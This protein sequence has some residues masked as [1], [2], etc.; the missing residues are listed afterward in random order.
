[1][2]ARW[3]RFIYRIRRLTLVAAIP[4]LALAAYGF[5][6]GVA[7]NFNGQPPVEAGRAATLIDRELPKL[8]NPFDLIFTSKTAR[9]SDAA[10]RNAMLSA[11]APLAT[12]PRV[13]VIQTPYTS[14]ASFRALVSRNGH[15]AL[16]IVSVNGTFRQ[17]LDAYPSLRRRV[18]SDT[19]RID[20]TGNLAINQDFNTYLNGDLARSSGVVLPLALILLLIVFGTIVSAVLPLGVAALALVAGLAS[21]YVLGRFTDITQY[22]LNLVALIGLGVAIDYSLFITSRFRQELA[23][24]RDVGESVSMAVATAGRAIFFSGLTVAIGLSGMFFYQGIY[25]ATMGLAGA[26]AIALAVLCAL[27][28]LPALLG[29][30]GARV[31]RL[32][33]PLVGGKPGHDG[34]FWHA[35][36]TWVM[37]HPVSALIPAVGFLLL[38]SWPI[39]HINLANSD[40]RALPPQAPTRQASDLITRDFPREG[41]NEVLAVLDY[42]DGNPLSP[43]RVGYLYDLNRRVAG[44]A[45]VRQ[46]KSPLDAAPGLS[47]PATIALLTKPADQQTPAVRQVIHQ[48]SGR[49]IVELDILSHTRVQSSDAR[50]LVR[51]I[52]ALPSPPGG[53]HLVT[54]NTAFD[55]DVI[56]YVKSRTVPAVAFIMVVTY[57]I[58]FLLVG[59]LI[60]PL[61][62]VFMNLLSIS[63]S[64]GAL[65][66]IFQEGHLRSQLNFTPQEID[67]TTLILLFCIVFGLSMDY[68][69]FLL[70]RIQ[71]QFRLCDD[72]RQ[73][74]ATGLEKSG[75]LITGA[76]AIM[77][78][79]FLAFGGLANTVIIKEIGLGLAIAV[80]MDATIV[81]GV[82]VP[83]LM[84]LLG[85]VNWWAPES[86]KRIYER[87]GLEERSAAPPEEALEPTPLKV[88]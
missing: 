65:V 38:V 76:A 40:I 72:T 67:P 87:L 29:V 18:H 37:R 42:P 8:P 46:L 71:E 69:V 20:A 84:R 61:K 62:A 6:A 41:Q 80:A 31:N 43:R 5:V 49:H 45:G 86:L 74:V 4:F 82:V 28:L 9:A 66:W 24:G 34:S 53:Q 10:F 19:L 44:L 27:T 57:V 15:M 47:R 88:V 78:G 30:L 22:A 33:V 59:S 1:M 26:V 16:A 63:A 75:R 12:D 85:S 81:R 7:P 39:T 13:K 11:L 73:A 79:V 56:D 35:L 70:T 52:R 17:G 55:I 50:T 77:V 58:L 3:G 64:F 25:L 54:G 36:A 2:F 21:V 48:Y 14:P 51:T 68:E 60:L 83:A 23:Q 32:Q